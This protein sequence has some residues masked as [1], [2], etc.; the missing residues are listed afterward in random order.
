[1]PYPFSHPDLT[2]S[3]EHIPIAEMRYHKLAARG[4]LS[5]LAARGHENIKLT[6]VGGRIADPRTSRQLK[7]TFPTRCAPD[8]GSDCNTQHSVA[9]FEGRLRTTL[10]I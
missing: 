1:M 10:S 6:V 5:A 2:S 8:Y 3:A 7:T 4:G 9:P